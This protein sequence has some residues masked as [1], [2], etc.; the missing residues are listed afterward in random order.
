VCAGR[1]SVLW[2]RAVLTA[3]HRSGC[4]FFTHINSAAPFAFFLLV[5]FEAAV[6]TVFSH[7]SPIGVLV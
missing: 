3:H 5:R 7:S 2:T 1:R 6:T 4:Y